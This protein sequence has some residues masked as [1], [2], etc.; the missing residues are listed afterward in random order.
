MYHTKEEGLSSKNY[1]RKGISSMSEPLHKRGGD[2]A[3]GRETEHKR[4][5][6]ALKRTINLNGMFYNRY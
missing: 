1:V 4:L 3:T 2:H 6:I 5:G